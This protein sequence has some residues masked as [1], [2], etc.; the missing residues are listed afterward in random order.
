MLWTFGKENMGFENLENAEIIFRGITIGTVSG[1]NYDFPWLHGRFL[2]LPSFEK[3][4]DGYTMLM[5]GD[6]DESALLAV[7]S[8]IFENRHWRLQS[9]DGQISDIEPP[10]IHPNEEHIDW[11]LLT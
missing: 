4:R 2:A 11:K 7:D 1:V 10:S 9:S 8:E 5:E 6:Y 3:Y